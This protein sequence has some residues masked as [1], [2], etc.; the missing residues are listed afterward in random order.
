MIW[1]YFLINHDYVL[2]NSWSKVVLSRLAS[3]RW[4]LFYL[5]LFEE[6]DRKYVYDFSKNFYIIFPIHI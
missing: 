3:S 6:D 2:C 1:R 4:Q 5:D